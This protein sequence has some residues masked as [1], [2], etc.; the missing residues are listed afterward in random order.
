MQVIED[1]LNSILHSYSLPFLG[2]DIG[3]RQKRLYIILTVEE[4]DEQTVLIMDSSLI[5]IDQDGEEFEPTTLM[6]MNPSSA[7]TT[8][9]CGLGLIRVISP[10]SSQIVAPH[11]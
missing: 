8:T 7:L 10:Q 4:Q 6:I 9:P 3:L 1:N 2:K 5:M 11:E